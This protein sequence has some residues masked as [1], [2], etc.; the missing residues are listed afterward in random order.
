MPEEAKTKAAEKKKR[1]RGARRARSKR[2]HQEGP[3]AACGSAT[4]RRLGQPS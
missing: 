4:V 3:E 2:E 1:T